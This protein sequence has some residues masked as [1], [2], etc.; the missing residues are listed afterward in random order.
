MARVLPPSFYRLAVADVP[1]FA[2]FEGSRKADVCIVGGGF[3]GLSAAI[4]LADA[5]A[6]VV[7]LEAGRIADGASGRSGGQIHSGQRQNQ[8]WLERRFGFERARLLWDMAEE[9]KALVRSLI[10]RFAIPCDLRAGVIEALHRPALL[11][12][13]AA[14][15]EALSGRYG[16]DLVTLL[17]RAQTA[18]AL[19][20]HLYAGA[21][22]DRG[23]GHLDPYRFALGLARAA[24]GLGA[25]VHENSPAVALARQGGPVVRTGH[26]EIRADNVIVATNGRSGKF[27]AITRRRIVG[28]NS[29]VVVTEP[30][31][32]EGDAILPGGDAAADSRFVVRYWR[33]TPDRR[34][35]FG[36]G[37][38]RAARRGAVESV[39]L[40]RL[41]FVR[42]SARAVFAAR[43]YAGQG[44]ALAPLVGKLLA[45]AA[46]GR[47]GRLAAFTEIPIPALPFPTW[48]RRAFV[49][50]A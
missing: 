28:V 36:G 2:P 50:L 38:S 27:E 3:T 48:L 15:V 42:E 37:D 10:V 20:S 25:R 35:I 19:G 6:D 49:T 22:R 43:G 8:L 21:I 32:A 16:Y 45:E 46:L 18:E 11:D 30:L 33:K 44:G 47:P 1:E 9:A 34:L 14:L 13:A 12:E 24:S 7:L 40:L 41:P 26:G 23:G 39:T 17:D 29:F 31:G 5:G 4:H